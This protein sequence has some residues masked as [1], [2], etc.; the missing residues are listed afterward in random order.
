MRDLYFYNREEYNLYYERRGRL[1][2]NFNVTEILKNDKVVTGLKIGAMGA[3]LLCTIVTA[4]VTTA[5][6]KNTLAKLV[7][8]HFNKQ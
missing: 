2:K 5:E 4:I 8:D 6:N 1:M 7:D 3:T